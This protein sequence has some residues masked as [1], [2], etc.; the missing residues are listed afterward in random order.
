MGPER[1]L[2]TWTEIED[3]PAKTGVYAWYC[4]HSLTEFDINKLIAEIAGLPAESKADASTLV[5]RFL[6]SHLFSVFVEDPYR[7]SATGPLK[8]TY[9]GELH[10]EQTISADLIFRLAEEPERLRSLKKVLEEAVPEFA[11]PIYIGMSDNLSSRLRR[12]KKL[13]ETYRAGDTLPTPGLTPTPTERADH[14]F[15][16]DVA[17]RGFSLNRLAVSVRFID[18]PGNVHVDAE[19]ILNRINYPLC[20]RN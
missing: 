8:P 19:N 14:S 7:V 18:A 4:R 15:A 16:R 13:I 5:Q 2:Y 9:K 20:G 3:I 12:H 1:K 11:S 6:E 10:H 17:R